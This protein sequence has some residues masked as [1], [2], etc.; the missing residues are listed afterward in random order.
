MKTYPHIEDGQIIDLVRKDEHD[1]VVRE[2]NE[3]L[4]DFTQSHLHAS[5]RNVQTI[6]RQ[7]VDLAKWQTM[8]ELLKTAL[9]D[10]KNRAMDKTIEMHPDDNAKGC[11]DDVLEWAETALAAYDA[12][13]AGNLPDPLD[14]AVKRMEAV[15]MDELDEIWFAR[16]GL[17]WIFDD[18]MERIRARLILAAKGEQP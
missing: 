5:A 8:A 2:L 4:S 13:K 1:A 9:T 15:Q 16:T 18:A 17:E 6:Q 14:E 11:V 3:R 10:C 12:A 7:A